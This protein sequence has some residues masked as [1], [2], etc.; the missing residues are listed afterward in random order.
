MGWFDWLFR[1]LTP[2]PETVGNLAREKDRAYQKRLPELQPHLRNKPERTKEELFRRLGVRGIQLRYFDPFAGVAYEPEVDQVPTH[3]HWYRA[4]KRTGGYRLLYSPN[5][6]LKE[7]QRKLVR[8]VFAKLAVHPA[9]KGFRR[10]ESIATH[11]RLHVGQA[12]VVRMD[13]RDFFH[14]TRA[15]R[16]WEYFRLA[17]WD[18]E[19]TLLLT[20]LCCKWVGRNRGLPQGAPTSPVLS[21]VVNYRMDARLAGLARRSNA[22]YSRYA[23]DIVFS[24]AADERRFIRGVIRR[25]RSILWAFGYR[26]HGPPKLRFMRRHQAQ[27][28]TGLVVNEKVRLPRKVRRWLRAVEHHLSVGRQATLTRQQLRGWQALREMIRKQG[29]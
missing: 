16:V 11:A 29:G 25:V 24:F 6:V 21:N 22:V 1:W 28:V 26:M 5:P 10:G 19:A 17:G 12:V 14:S 27:L 9:A 4:P 23:D 3:Y 2:K 13:I 7:L 18:E 15:S 8:R 20:K